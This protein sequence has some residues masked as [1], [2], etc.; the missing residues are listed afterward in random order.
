M[1]RDLWRTVWHKCFGHGGEVYLSGDF[2]SNCICGNAHSDNWPS[3]RE[4]AWPLLQVAEN[5]HRY[6]YYLDLPAD[7]P[8]SKHRDE[9]WT[10]INKTRTRASKGEA[11][12]ST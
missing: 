5:I 11:R 1:R 2:M 12:R 8:L 9:L 6:L 10:V 3:L 4:S 7:A